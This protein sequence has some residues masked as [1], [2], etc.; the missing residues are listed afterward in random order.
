MFTRR[1]KRWFLAVAVCLLQTVS[2]Y[3]QRQVAVRNNLLYDA[4]LTANLGLE[5]RTDSVWSLGLNAGLNAWDIDK[6]KNRK[7][8][9]MLFAPFVRHY[10]ASSR[11]RL[12]P[13]DSLSPR[14]SPHDSLRRRESLDAGLRR[15]FW[16]LYSVYS[17]YNASNVHFPFGLY[18]SVKDSRRQGDLVALGGSYG[19]NWR[20][21]DHWQLEAELG[22][23]LGYTWY[24]EYECAQCGVYRGRDSKLFLIPKLGLSIVWNTARKVP[25]IPLDP[26]AP[27]V[28]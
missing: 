26:L 4:T 11:R 6:G 15:S 2:G 24:K 3:G 7:W 10:N 28:S 14:L 23:A 19:Y 5:L 25:A 20:I 12:S 27:L 21:S 16:A 17:H 18:P 22:L 8:R 9:H 13:H 1:L